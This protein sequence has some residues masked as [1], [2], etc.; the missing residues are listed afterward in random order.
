MKRKS[1][2]SKPRLLITGGA[3]YIGSVMARFFLARGH[4]VT[5]LD[6]FMYR[7]NSLL[8]CCREEGFSVVSADC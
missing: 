8:D 6:N 1:D 4:T 3:G 7:Q 2:P 5:V